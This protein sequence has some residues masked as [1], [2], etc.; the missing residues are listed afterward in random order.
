MVLH[1]TKL[2]P[3]MSSFGVNLDD[4]SNCGTGNSRKW[5]PRAAASDCKFWRN[6][7]AILE[8]LDGESGDI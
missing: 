3:V 5:Q 8:T 2:D 6:L 7:T 1:S 4:E